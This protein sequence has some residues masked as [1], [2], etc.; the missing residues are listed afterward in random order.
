MEENKK[1][2][3]KNEKGQTSQ[4]V[5]RPSVRRKR[6]NL[7][8]A[9]S[10]IF[11]LFWVLLFF[12]WIY[13]F[14]VWKK[15]SWSGT[16]KWIFTIAIIVVFIIILLSLKA[17]KK[18]QYQV[19]RN[20]IT[21]LF[22][23]FGAALLSILLT[24]KDQ[25]ILLKLFVIGYFSFFPAWLY[26][27]FIS[28][29]GKT[30]WDEYVLN[31][32]RL[33]IDRYAFL[34]EPPKESLFNKMWEKD[35]RKVFEN[36][37]PNLGKSIY[38]K[39]YEGLYGPKPVEGSPP[40]AAFRGENFW[41]VALATL[42]ISVGW[43]LVVRPET[44]F[45]LNLFKSV[46]FTLSGIP[47]ISLDIMG[48]A[49]LGSYFYVLQMLV[50]RYFQND[51]KTSAYVH[52]IM[53]I[54]IVFLLVWIIYVVWPDNQGQTNL[55]GLAFVIGVFPHIGW[56]A[57]TTLIKLP[58]RPLIRSLRKE[59][60]LSDLDG[61]NIWY[62]SRLLE[63]GI[64]DLQNIAT[65]NL[66]DVMLATRIPVER[67]VDWVDQSLL[68]LHLGK[69]V[70]GKANRKTL[71]HYGIRTATDL[72]DVVSVEENDFINKILG[73]LN[74]DEKEPSKIRSIIATFQNEPNFFHILKWKRFSEECLKDEIK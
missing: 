43:V 72:L 38:E 70:D 3:R 59:Y 40:F 29:K 68:Y 51:L 33:C 58:F 4:P 27:Q 30:L 37:E 32:Y 50:R 42:L 54:L 69:G 74:P 13:Y 35:K 9:T 10:L 56:K 45:S 60:P 25:T 39:K 65:A 17:K 61:L 19:Y 63:E 22:I 52:A 16:V 23:V 44:I 31:L 11:E 57:L 12:G 36:K 15:L 28:L 8:D 53:R 64:E 24:V 7:S 46:S 67:L 73:I 62:E 55:K 26:L 6:P 71:S 47:M 18:S 2:N 34:P 49:F 21:V 5:P 41:P 48:Y 66:V 1:E 14:S 20:F